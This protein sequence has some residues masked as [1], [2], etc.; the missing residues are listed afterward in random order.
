MADNFNGFGLGVHGPVASLRDAESVLELR[1]KNDPSKVYLRLCPESW[2]KSWVEEDGSWHFD[3]LVLVPEDK[4]A[5]YRVKEANRER[6]TDPWT[7][8]AGTEVPRGVGYGDGVAELQPAF[9]PSGNDPTL[10]LGTG[11]KVTCTSTEAGL[12]LKY[13]FSNGEVLDDTL[14]FDPANPPNLTQM[15]G[16]ACFPSLDAEAPGKTRVLVPA[17]AVT[18]VH[19][20]DA[21]S[22][23]NLLHEDGN[24]EFLPVR[25][26]TLDLAGW[27][28]TSKV[29]K[30]LI[31]YED[32][33]GQEHEVTLPAKDL[34]LTRYYTPI[35]DLLSGQTF[36]EDEYAFVMSG[37]AGK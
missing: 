27:K 16:I 19:G 11:P 30:I 10:D 18:I 21:P 8:P 25:T 15:R 32:A 5:E 12:R 36:M 22:K 1:D 6:M 4:L 13:T 28:N 20:F 2:K 29:K 23:T 31:Q 9:I 26:E 17:Q 7:I 33:D 34:R 3:G 35:K 37:K 14:Q 24:V